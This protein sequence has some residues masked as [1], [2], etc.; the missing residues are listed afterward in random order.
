M[1]PH[2]KLKTHLAILH[3]CMWVC[4]CVCW[5]IHKQQSLSS[6]ER[7]RC[8][9]GRWITLGS[10]GEKDKEMK[11][12]VGV[13]CIAVYVSFKNVFEANMVKYADIHKSGEQQQCC[14]TGGL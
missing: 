6:R 12:V 8:T 3:V 14:F 1:I 7:E 11:Q 2:S 5:I 13:H 10:F 9:S 4:V